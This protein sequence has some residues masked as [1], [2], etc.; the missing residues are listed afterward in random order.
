M[1]AD[2]LLEKEIYDLYMKCGLNPSNTI[3]VRTEINIGNLHEQF[4]TFFTNQSEDLYYSW[5]H[6][7]NKESDTQ[8]LT[9]N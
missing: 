8:N 1:S 3:P 6:N 5:Q 4:E 7:G 2:I 9:D